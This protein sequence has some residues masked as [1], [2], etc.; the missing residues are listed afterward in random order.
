MEPH[1]DVRFDPDFAIG[2]MLEIAQEQSVRGVL[3]KLVCRI[4]GRP[5]VARVRIWL[6]DKG[7]VCATCVR[8][9]DCPDQ[10]RCL[11][12]VAGG[13]NL[14]GHSRDEQEYMQ[15][16][17]RYARIPLGAGVVG[18]IGATGRQTALR[19]LDQDPAELAYIDWLQR[20]QIRGFN[21]VPIVHKGEVLNPRICSR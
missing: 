1:P 16:T 9:P 20:E 17:D 6:I 15:M 4:L 18:K 13:N 8:R 19:N 21:G 12:A 14:I 2:L 10:T 5:A 7:D 3:K 11:H